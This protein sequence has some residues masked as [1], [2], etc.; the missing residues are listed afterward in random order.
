MAT[1]QALPDKSVSHNGNL[2]MTLR[3]RRHIVLMT[4]VHN[5]KKSGL[6]VFAQL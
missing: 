3:T 1:N 4:F 5:L 6:K 2:K